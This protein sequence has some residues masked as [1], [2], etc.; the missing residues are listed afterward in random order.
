MSESPRRC[1]SCGGA[2]GYTKRYGCRYV[3]ADTEADAL[4]R[5]LRDARLLITGA[6]HLAQYKPDMTEWSNRAMEWQHR[7]RTKAGATK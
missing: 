1:P 4:R 7:Q 2:C 5:D 3:A 6:L